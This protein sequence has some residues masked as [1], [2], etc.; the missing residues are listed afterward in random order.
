[1]RILSGVSKC[2]KRKKWKYLHAKRYT[3]AILFY[4]KTK[5]GISSSFFFFFVAII[6]T[7]SLN[8]YKSWYNGITFDFFEYISRVL[9]S[10]RSTQR[11]I[12]RINLFLDIFFVFAHHFS[13]ERVNSHETLLNVQNRLYKFL[14]DTFRP[15]LDR[16]LAERN[17]IYWDFIS[18]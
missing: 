14:L 3:K 7:Y 15:F 6:L 2:E 8:R 11:H 9:T 17:N 13:V 1:M 5:K 12:I 16:K 10:C 18:I 4:S